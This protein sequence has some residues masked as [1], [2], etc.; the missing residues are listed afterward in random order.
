MPKYILSTYKPVTSF[1]ELCN[2]V[3]IWEIKTEGDV[4]GRST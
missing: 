2:P 1:D 3:G 4:E